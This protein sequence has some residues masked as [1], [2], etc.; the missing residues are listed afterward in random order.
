MGAENFDLASDR[1]WKLTQFRT[2]PK[3]LFVLPLDKIKLI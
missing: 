2:N 1:Q 3:R